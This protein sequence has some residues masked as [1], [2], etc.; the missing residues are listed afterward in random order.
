MIL[1]DSVLTVTIPA[2]NNYYSLY[3][4]GIFSEKEYHEPTQTTNLFYPKN[5]AIFL[6][7]TYPTHRTV[8]L[9]R[10]VGLESRLKLTLLPSLSK[11]VNVLF[12]FS[13]S[14]VDKTKRAVAHLNAN[15]KG[16]YHWSDFFYWRLRQI[17]AMKGSLK[18][19]LIKQI[20]FKE[21]R[22]YYGDSFKVIKHIKNV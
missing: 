5:S 14:R 22:N 7:Y 4:D 10:N 12:S 17:I 18:Y 16:A 15:Y 19:Y 20:V 11:R 6:Y 2:H 21:L 13:A 9:V 3:A 8:S 1:N